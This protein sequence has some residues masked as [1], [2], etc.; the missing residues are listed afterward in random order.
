MS[1]RTDGCGSGSGKEG[2]KRMVRAPAGT[3]GYGDLRQENQDEHRGTALQPWTEA[4]GGARYADGSQSQASQA[5]LCKK[6][7][8]S[9]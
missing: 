6:V 3:S 4:G 7:V 1:Y 2:D 8:Y 5:Y 9:E